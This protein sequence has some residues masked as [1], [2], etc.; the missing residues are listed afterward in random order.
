[1]CGN[2]DNRG[3]S[4]IMVLC[5]KRKQFCTTMFKQLSFSQFRA[6]TNIAK[7]FQKCILQNYLS[8]WFESIR[9]LLKFA[10]M[11]DLKRSTG[12]QWKKEYHDQE[13]V[14]GTTTVSGGYSVTCVYASKCVTTER[15]ACAVSCV[16]KKKGGA[17]GY[18]TYINRLLKIKSLHRFVY[19]LNFQRPNS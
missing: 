4:A 16:S 17:S 11:V 12:G 14:L 6:I 9:W 19:P 8:S 3:E 13:Q 7:P 1:M 10:R 18:S 2:G 5:I 15:N